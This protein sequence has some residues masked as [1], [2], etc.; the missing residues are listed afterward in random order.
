[1]RPFLRIALALGASV[2]VAASAAAVILR[3]QSSTN[4]VDTATVYS[5]DLAAAGIAVTLLLAIGTWWYKGHRRSAPRVGTAE[6]VAAAAERL[7]EVMGDR[8]RREVAIRR[9][10]TPTPAMVRWRW[11]ADEVT[12]SR[13]DIATPP[14]PGTGPAPLPDS[15]E[16]HEL[17]STGVVTRLHDELYARLPHGR[18]A[19]VGGPGAGKTGAMILLLLAALD[20]RASLEGG[21]R[22]RVPVPVWLTMGRW[23]PV[24]TSLQD[25]A[26]EAMERDHPALRAAEYGLNAARELLRGGRV[27]LF[28]DGLDEMP[29]DVRAHAV[30]RVDDEARGLRVV[31]TSRIAEFQQALRSGRLDNTAVIELR[32]VRPEAAA[33]YLLQGQAGSDRERWN[34]LGAYLAHHPGSVAARALDN[35]LT[36]SAARD[37]YK[38]QDPMLLTDTARFPTT[39]A[40]RQHLFNQLLVTAYPDERQRGHATRWLAWIACRLGSSRDLSWWEI[41]GW[42]PLW[43]LRVSFGCIG[44]L[45]FGLAAGLTAAHVAGWKTGLLAGVPAGWIFGI[46]VAALLHNRGFERYP[47]AFVP[48]L[49]RL[50]ELGWILLGGLIGGLVIGFTVWLAAA[51][52]VSLGAGLGV[53]A[54]PGLVFAFAAGYIFGLAIGLALGFGYFCT[55]PVAASPSATAVGTYRADRRTSGIAALVIGVVAGVLVGS[56]FGFIPGLVTGLGAGLFAA[57]IAVQVPVVKLTEIILRFEVGSSISFQRTLEDAL[58]RQLLRQAGTVYQFRHAALQDHLAAMST[59]QPTAVSGT[60][61]TN[62]TP[63]DG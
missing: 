7:M 20:Y 11:A 25:W 45:L 53:R 43:K 14:A 42:V 26:V 59:Q 31:V 27:A 3:I 2:V 39:H 9:I 16:P 35:P 1:V 44:G 18:M 37:T 57:L 29:E 58:D 15:G 40:V 21:Q 33:S 6:Q 46:G 50:R 38:N 56:A 22:A 10:V 17:L 4:P 34:R 5:G 51:L 61:A 13:L 55:I 36:L 49:P 8:W 52:A 30:K 28:L 48:R 60:S 24:T 23:D 47:R 54:G 32:P 41:P 12:A 63:R 19:I 62:V